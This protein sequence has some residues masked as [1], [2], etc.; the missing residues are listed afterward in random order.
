MAPNSTIK[1]ILSISAATTIK[2]S[3]N[4]HH[5]HKKPHLNPE[6]GNID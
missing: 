1:S 4:P 2:S 6:Y 5:P 3:A